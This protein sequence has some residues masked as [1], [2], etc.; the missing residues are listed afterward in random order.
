MAAPSKGQALFD[1]MTVLTKSSSF[2]SQVLQLSEKEMRKRQVMWPLSVCTM[3]P[4]LYP[5]SLSGGMRKRVSCPSHRLGS[6]NC[7][8]RRAHDGARPH[9][10]GL[11][12]RDD[13]HRQG[14]NW[15]SPV[16][17]SATMSPQRS[18]LVT[19]LLSCPEA[20]NRC[21]CAAGELESTHPGRSNRRSLAW[22]LGKTNSRGRSPPDKVR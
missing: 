9:H 14:Q 18:R 21:P 2:R 4:D 15:E 11:R 5:A 1:S 16:W 13:S 3:S 17:S 10:H 7:S 6:R 8:L 20:K 19:R 12:R 22:F